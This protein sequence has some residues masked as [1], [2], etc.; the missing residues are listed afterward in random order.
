VKRR[1]IF[2]SYIPF[3]L[4][5]AITILYYIFLYFTFKDDFNSE[6]KLAQ[7]KVINLEKRHLKKSAD[8]FKLTFKLMKKS[9]YERTIEDLESFLLYEINHGHIEKLKLDGSDI[10]YGWAPDS[11]KLNL[12]LYENRYL[13]LTTP[14]VTYLLYITHKNGKNY[15]AGINKHLIDAFIVDEMMKYLDK[16]NKNSS[17]FIVLEK[18]KRLVPDKNGFYGYVFHMP[19]RYI[20]KE[21][22]KLYVNRPDLK[23]HYFRKEYLECFKKGLPGC[24]VTSYYENPHNGKVEKK[25]TYYTYLRDYNFSISKGIYASEI[26]IA[27]RGQYHKMLT[28]FKRYFILAVI[29]YFIAYLIGLML[30]I[31]F[32]KKVRKELI[33]DYEGL[34]Q[35]LQ[36]QVYYDELTGLPNRNKL[37]EDISNRNYQGLIVFDIDD[38]SSINEVFGFDFG[39]QILLELKE[40]FK[41]Y[42]NL[43]RVGSDEFA[44][45]F[46][47]KVGEKEIME[48]LEHEFEY[49]KVDIRFICGSS[50]TKSR[51][52]HTAEMAMNLA[53][54]QKKKY[55]MFD[56]S[57]EKVQK[58]NLSLI[59]KF[60]HALREEKII[61][62][63]HCIVNR[64]QEIV[65]YEALMRVEIDSEIVSPIKFMELIKEANIYHEFSVVMIKKVFQ[66]LKELDKPVSINLSFKDIVNE[67]VNK[68]LF[69][70]LEKHGGD[71]IIFEMLESE[72]FDNLELV[73]EFINKAR[74]YN[75]QIAIDDFGSGYSNFVNVIDFNPDIIKLDSSLVQKIEDEKY[76]K[77]VKLIVDFAKKFNIKVV[78]EFISSKERF[79]K[80][81]SLG[82]DEFQGFY[83]CKPAP[84]SQLMLKFH[85][86][87][88]I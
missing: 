75:V 55:L 78:A 61:P 15:I 81:K 76:E 1:I 31:P 6:L 48:V 56:E 8:S 38:F 9:I 80:L 14:K 29:V 21:G 79:E 50:N 88:Q 42:R 19:N 63:Y 65:K 46:Y 39:N 44:L 7:Q 20:S 68:T 13:L 26:K 53:K 66:Q 69:E 64:N 30:L 51:I 70:L 24:F 35:Q 3:I 47:E 17:S 10:I 33:K 18:I 41:D 2:L 57:F 40:K 71:N 12:K 72:G 4:F 59:Q 58:E 25:I 85:Q 23:G 34:I 67:E 49:E 77:I 45:A 11:K 74:K 5:F 62:F 52:F 32:I 87:R 60:Q 16:I 43:Y 36:R 22:A 54:K 86:K 82:V 84:L 28:Q 37:F 27:L 73:Y 83:F